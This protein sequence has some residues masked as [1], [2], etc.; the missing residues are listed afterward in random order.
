MN[1]T[2]LPPL[3]FPNLFLLFSVLVFSSLL[4]TSESTDH[5]YLQNCQPK[6]CGNLIN[7]SF[8]FWFRSLQP[9]YCGYPAFELRCENDT[10]KLSI[11]EEDYHVLD[12]SYDKRTITVSM[13]RFASSD[14]CLLPYY[15]LS[16]SLTPFTISSLNRELVFVYNCSARKDGFVAITCHNNRSYAYLGGTYRIEESEGSFGSCYTV[17]MPVLTSPDPDVKKYPQ[18]LANG[19]LLNWT[20]PDCSECS[21]SKGQCGYN[22]ETRNFMCICPDR[23]HWRSCYEGSSKT[24]LTVGLSTAGGLSFII[25]C[26]L[27]FLLYRRKKKKQFAKSNLFD[28]NTS[29]MMSK[30]EC[31]QG[32]SL[33]SPIFSYDELH[34]ATN[35]FD[36]SN[37][38]GDGG[39]GTVYKGNLKD[40]RVVA[41]KRLYENNYRRLEQFMN[42]VK[43][44]SLLR[45]QN[46]VTL[47]GCT[48]RRSRELL[49]V[50]EFIPN[51]TVAD[52]LHG[53]HASESLLPWKVR[54][55]IAIETAD[56]LN[57][58][59]SIEPQ[60]I[61]RDVKTTNILLDNSFHVKV[62]DF[63]LSRLLPLDATHVSTAPQ[64]TAGYVDPEY[65]QCYQLTDKS[66]VYSFGVVLMELVSSMPAVDISRDRNEVNLSSLA[67]RKIQQQE[68]DEFVDR[69]LGYDSDYRIKVM[70]S[71]V[72]ALGLRCLHS[73]GEVRPGIKEVLEI[74]RA[75]EK[76]GWKSDDS[77]LAD[78][79]MKEEARL[80]KSGSPY[81]PDSV[82]DR[83]K[84]SSSS[85]TSFTT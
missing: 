6:S 38:L 35:G 73:E 66:D 21:R 58:L 68:L 46:L 1:P 48:S 40:G 69:R 10:T 25:F 29:L 22:N 61:H 49:L 34:E 71:E 37:E 82:T 72:A 53:S 11:P 59:H 5:Y 52:H 75:I 76:S 64:G 60:I 20:S 19:F 26:L 70:I 33:T 13:A 39:F 16:F 84:S 17:V 15:N 54:L 45:H 4:P 85:M 79:Q 65:H 18:L 77:L 30:F 67:I 62:A 50:Y 23:A 63:G 81:S 8:P 55:S 44:L 57:Y 12:I 2:I 74:L 80:L 42:E 24:A 41:V 7:V 51:G 56:A 36:A 47:Y 43:I 9:D 31:E 27:C 14:T 83:W 28:R 32:S 3:P 78:T